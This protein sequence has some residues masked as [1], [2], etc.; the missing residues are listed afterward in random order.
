MESLLLACRMMTLPVTEMIS[1]LLTPNLVNI[2]VKVDKGAKYS[3]LKL[4]SPLHKLTCRVGSWCYLPPARG[5]I[6]AI[7]PTEAL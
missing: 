4:A 3:S 2:K 7:T 1:L 6:A 5:K